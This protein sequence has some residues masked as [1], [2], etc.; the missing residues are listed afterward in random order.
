MPTKVYQEPP[1]CPHCDTALQPERVGAQRFVCPCC[2]RIF[3]IPIGMM[4]G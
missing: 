3:Y 2:S 1:A 4:K